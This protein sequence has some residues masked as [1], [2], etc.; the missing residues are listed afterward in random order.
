MLSAPFLAAA[1]AIAYAIYRISQIGQRERYLPPGPPTV[2]LL[3]NIHIFPR[4]L[5]YFQYVPQSRAYDPCSR[6]HRF[7]AWA[8]EYGGVYSLKM[9]PENVVV[10]SSAKAFREIIDKNNIAADRP[11]NHFADIVTSGGL[12]IFL[13]VNHRPSFILCP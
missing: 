2:P 12:N 7:S 11:P 13:S 9:G 6:C 1:L 3:G 4:F 5:A 10:I 8:R